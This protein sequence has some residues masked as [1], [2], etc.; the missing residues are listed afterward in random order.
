MITV[1]MES[2]NF[3]W[4]P[5][6]YSYFIKDDGTT[7]LK[8][9]LSIDVDIYNR[10]NKFISYLIKFKKRNNKKCRLTIKRKKSWT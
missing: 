9:N 5:I 8:F 1:E 7:W 3:D 10:F 2:P 4:Y 6:D